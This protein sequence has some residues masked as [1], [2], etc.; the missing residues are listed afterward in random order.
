MAVF[1]RIF[2]IVALLIWFVFTGLIALPFQI[3]GWKNI[4]RVSFVS[5]MWGTGVA[6]IINLKIN[7]T[8]DLSS[9]KG[10]LIISNHQGYI[11]IVTHSA[12]FPIRFTPKAEI[13]RW[14]FL[15]QLLGLSRPVWVDRTSKQKSSLLLEKFRDTMEHGIPLIVYP[16]GTSDDGR[17]GLLP[18]KS[19][20]FE[21]VTSKNLSMLP[22]VTVYQSPPGYASVA[23]YGDMTLLPHMWQLL[24]YPYI[25]ANIHVLN[26]VLPDNRNRKELANYVHDLMD[27]EWKMRQQIS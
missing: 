23:W 27:K 9:F 13:A 16:E 26:I 2:R 22:V 1:R 18:F 14:P 11:D 20:P 17:N 5:R 3:G 7:L 6:W 10:G 8:G 19:T 25:L 4:R 12:A 24:S 21:A 15:G